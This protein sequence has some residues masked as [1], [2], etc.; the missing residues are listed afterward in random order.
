MVRR[1]LAWPAI[2]V[3]LLLAAPVEAAAPARCTGKDMLAE[4]AEKAPEIHGRILAEA[5][6]TANTE[7]VLWRVEREGR[8]P[9]WLLGTVHLSDERVATLTPAVRKALAEAKTVALEIADLSPAALASVLGSATSLVTYADGHRLD[10]LLTPEDF[11]KV[12]TA[13]GAAG[14]PTDAVAEFRPWIVYMLLSVSACERKRTEAGAPVL[15]MRIAEAAKARGVPVVGLETIESQLAAM[16]ALP[17]DKEIEVL[18]AMLKYVER[19]DDLMET[20]LQF[21][22][23][24]QMGA[25]WPFEMAMARAADIDPTPLAAVEKEL[26]ERRNRGMAEAARPLLA[27]GG[28]FIAVGAL[29]LVGDEGLVALLR[30]DGYTVTPVE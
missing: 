10:S 22:L 20:V 2:A 18:R 12:R 1:G 24:R 25:A 28:A 9:S 30:R 16:A 19:S 4:L 7:A 15:D 11:A 29:H 14:V 23:K 6:E 5:R 27:A 21:Y 17:D 13:L 3:G 8:A 26:I